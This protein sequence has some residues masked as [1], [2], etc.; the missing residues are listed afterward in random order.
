M[1]AMAKIFYET[2]DLV[3]KTAIGFRN[4]NKNVWRCN[5]AM[6]RTS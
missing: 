4:T 6:S 3:S 1:P 5:N 2:V